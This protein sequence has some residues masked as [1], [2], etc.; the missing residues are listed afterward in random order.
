MVVY[1]LSE[2]LTS[3]MSLRV[4]FFVRTYFNFSLYTDPFSK[5]ICKSYG[6][7]P[8]VHFTTKCFMYV[9][10]EKTIAGFFFITVLFFS[11]NYRIFELPYFRLDDDLS[12]KNQMDSY[13][14][15]IYYTFIT[16][17]TVGYG[18]I[19][20]CTPPGRIISMILAI[21]GTFQMSILVVA[22]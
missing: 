21:W 4:Y 7:I 10:S 16:I 2:I 20:P 1:F 5:Q 9:H 15:A 17:A 6:F 22:V 19:C 11:F 12:V 3:F 13:F 18:D 8:G 14:V